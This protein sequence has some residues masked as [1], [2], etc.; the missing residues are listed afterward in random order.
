MLD[1]DAPSA[2]DDAMN[3]TKRRSLGE[4]A[5]EGLQRA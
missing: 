2:P 5:H 4:A 1:N 3:S